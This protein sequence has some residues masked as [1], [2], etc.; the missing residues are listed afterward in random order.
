[1]KTEHWV[2]N[3]TFLQT[4]MHN[5]NVQCNILLLQK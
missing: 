5:Y 1:M 4:D 3:I 2:A